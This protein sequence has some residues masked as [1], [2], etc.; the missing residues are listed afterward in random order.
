MCTKFEEEATTVYSSMIGYLEKWLPQY[1]QFQ[2]F[3][4]MS[5]SK[6][7]SWDDVEETL[8]FLEPEQTFTLIITNV[9]IN[10]ATFRCF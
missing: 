9:S 7:P 8:I 3:K 1:E 2:P 4:W 6:P 5:L 10:S